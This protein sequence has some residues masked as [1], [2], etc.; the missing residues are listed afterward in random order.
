[1]GAILRVEGARATYGK[2]EALRGVSFEVEEGAVGLLG[3]NGAG[4]S[5][6]I[7]AVL[8]LLPLSGGHISLMGEDA[9]KLGPALRDRVGYVPERE[10]TRPGMSGV[11]WVAFLGEI[12]GLPRSAA[13]E[14][15]HEV[16]QYV[17]LG[18]SRYR[19]VETYS[20]GMQQR[21]KLA[22]S[23]VHDPAL[24]LL[25]E[26]T[27]GMDPV[28]REEMLELCGDLVR[29]GKTLLLSTHILKD[30]EAVCSR[31]VILNR[32]EMLSYATVED[33][34]RSEAQHFLVQ[35]EGGGEAFEAACRK[36][37]VEVSD[38]HRGLYRVVLPPGESLKVIFGLA[39]EAGGTVTRLVRESTSL[40]TLFL[41]ALEQNG[42]GGDARI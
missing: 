42:G 8:G 31:V 17:G 5:T 6:L 41:N 37:G 38:G 16:L 30:V 34:T 33:W 28:G 13:V 19:N 22:A 25:D 4:K 32:G 14:R 36:A 9:R 35:W 40:E 29:Q 20:T 2:L 10:G 11:A 24:V 3:P 26:P 27:A 7:K 39:L 18:E 23:L 15:A 12:S 1:M 21:L